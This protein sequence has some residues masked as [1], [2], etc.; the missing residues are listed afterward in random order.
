[1]LLFQPEFEIAFE[2]QMSNE[3]I[4]LIYCSNSMAGSALHQAKPTALHVLDFFFLRERINTV[5]FGT[6]EFLYFLF[7][8]EP[9]VTFLS[10]LNYMHIIIIKPAKHTEP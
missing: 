4:I 6:D 9:A 2:E 1:M 8:Q 3:I 7:T 10:W 5:K